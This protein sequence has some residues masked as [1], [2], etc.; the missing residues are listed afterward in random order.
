MQTN[1]CHDSGKGASGV[2]VSYILCS[3]VYA[4]YDLQQERVIHETT[5]NLPATVACMPLQRFSHSA[6]DCRAKRG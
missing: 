3:I 4:A 6:W 2:I 1:I 5:R